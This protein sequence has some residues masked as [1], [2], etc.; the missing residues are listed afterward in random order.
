MKKYLI[1]LPAQALSSLLLGFLAAYVRLYSTGLHTALTWGL[2]P[3]FG[4]VSAYFLCVKGINNYL[5]WLLPPIMAVAG[6]FLAFF[7]P[8]S[9]AGAYM[10]IAVL[11]II[12][13]AA[14]DVVKKSKKSGGKNG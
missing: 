9:S 12:G 3:A 7:Y 10:L 6:H 4:A 13:A 11:S 2:L 14:G 5:A 1:L 8:P